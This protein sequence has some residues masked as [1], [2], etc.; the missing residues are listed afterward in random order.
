[1]RDFGVSSKIEERIWIRSIRRCR[2]SNTSLYWHVDI[3][4]VEVAS[5]EQCHIAHVKI[6]DGRVLSPF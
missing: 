3:L 6:P 4:V 1:M 2:L 5:K